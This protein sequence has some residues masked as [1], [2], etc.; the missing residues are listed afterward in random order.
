MLDLFFYFTFYLFGGCPRACRN[1]IIVAAYRFCLWSWRMICLRRLSVL[2]KNATDAKAII[3]ADVCGRQRYAHI[4]GA[5][6]KTLGDR[7]S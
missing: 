6:K 3:R 5:R 4:A 7:A 2:R 1:V